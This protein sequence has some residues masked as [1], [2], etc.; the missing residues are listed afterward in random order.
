[1]QD[2]QAFPFSFCSGYQNGPQL[3]VGSSVWL[4][5]FLLEA[6]FNLKYREGG[7]LAGKTD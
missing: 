2:E 3:L 1:M 6:D 7:E 4:I 5:G